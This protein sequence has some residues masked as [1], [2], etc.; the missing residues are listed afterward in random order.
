M[1]Y[2]ISSIIKRRV[3]ELASRVHLNSE[4]LT[5]FPNELSGGQLQRICIARAL[6][7][8][9]K[10]IVLDEPTSSLD[11]SVRAGILKL[12]SELQKDTG[13]ENLFC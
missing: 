6:A 3:K 7:T 10:L 1:L 9:P 13:I 8:N 2:F 12:L 4:L 5:R 11:L